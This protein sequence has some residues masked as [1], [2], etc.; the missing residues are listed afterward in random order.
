[1][2][3]SPRYAMGLVIG[4]VIGLLAVAAAKAQSLA[5]PRNAVP[6]QP[7]FIQAPWVYGWGKVY[8]YKLK[9][10]STT[11]QTMY[12]HIDFGS[13]LTSKNKGGLVAPARRSYKLVPGATKVITIRFAT[14][15]QS[16]VEGYYYNW[17]VYAD[18]S[19]EGMA[20][21]SL[22]TCASFDTGK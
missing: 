21:Q 20:L 13:M 15:A 3:R 17:C 8:T 7:Q 9:L 12:G 5:P 14:P 11:S 22:A 6:V 4:L 1:M 19:G 16:P 2:K 18:I 10:T